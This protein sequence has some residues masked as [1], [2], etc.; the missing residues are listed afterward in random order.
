MSNTVS[1]P[2]RE[3]QPGDW[4]CVWRKATW[5]ARKRK[6]DYN[7]EARFVGPG[8]VL[9]TEP[10]ILP[11]AREAMIW[12]LM[13]TQLWRCSPDQLRP[14]TEAEVSTDLIGR[15]TVL[16]RPVLDQLKVLRRVTDVRRE[17]TFDWDDPDLPETPHAEGAVLPEADMSQSQP[18]GDWE[19]SLE[20]M[21]DEWTR[22]LRA[23]REPGY[24]PTGRERLDPSQ[25]SRMVNRW[26]QLV[27][28]NENRKREGLPP[29]TQ[30][31]SGMPE[32]DEQMKKRVRCLG[33]EHFSLE[34]NDAMIIEEP[35]E[36]IL[37]KIEELEELA[38]KTAELEMLRET[39]REER[40]QEQHL[41]GLLSEACEKR[42]EVC[43]ISFD[44]EDPWMLIQQ[45]FIY[46]KNIMQGPSKE[47]VFNNLTPEHKK[48]F[49]EAMA[50]EIAEVLRSQA[51]R[52]AAEVMTPEELSERIIPMRWVL[53]W[54]FIPGV[55]DKASSRVTS[56]PAA[57]KE[58]GKPNVLAESG[59]Y[60]AKA[61]LVLLGYKHPDLAARDQHTGQRKLA[62]AAPTLTR[63]VRNLRLQASAPDEHEVES[64]DAKSAFLQ[65]AR[66]LEGKPLYTYAVAEVAHALGVKPGTAIQVIGAFYGLTIAPR[67]FWLDADEKLSQR[68]GTVHPCEKCL[69][70]FREEQP[71]YKVVGRIGAHV[72]D[73]LICRHKES[74]RWQKIRKSINEMYLWSPWQKGKFTF[75]GCEMTQLKDHTVTL[76]QTEFSN[77]LRPVEI[78][79]E[80]SRSDGDTLTPSEISQFRGAIMKAAWRAG[81]TGPQ[82]AARVNITASK[83]KAPSVLDLKETNKILKEMKKTANVGLLFPSFNHGKKAEERLTW[84]DMVML[85]FG[86]AAQNNRHDGSS[87]GGCISGF[88]TNKIMDGGEQPMSIIDWRSW[89]LERAAKG[90]NGCEAQALYETED[91]GWKCRIMWTLL[92]TPVLYRGQQEEAAS[93]IESLLIM[94]SRG[95]YDAITLSETAFC[96]MSSA[97]TGTEAMAIQRGTKP[98]TR[99]YATWVPSDLNLADALTK[100][101]PE[102]LKVYQLYLERRVWCVRFQADF[103]SARKAQKLRRRSTT[104][105]R[106]RTC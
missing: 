53:T 60:N 27:S 68:G 65:S 24:E 3:Y 59:Q 23:R 75:A 51:L 41:L 94:D 57:K 106:R 49:E 50:R 42:E 58:K 55:E 105:W 96:G 16:T 9:F 8:R 84:E 97:R 102:A 6:E 30:L 14:A 28:I 5:R 37:H 92:Y 77:A 44:V 101:S 72:D 45:G 71:P 56:K 31:P 69:W 21:S 76:T 79:N 78:A 54:K 15:G 1:R 39:I 100:I 103:V 81:Q 26:Q 64:A 93:R 80:A 38:R 98:H 13:G 82:Y 86:D 29:M 35:Y 52:A 66:K 99:C 90:S 7:P 87:T 85:H 4:V 17:G 20:Q 89:R 74:E 40:R 47:I 36:H 22:R 95:L 25:V 62:T 61:R 91:R 32:D 88:S 43:E 10:A 70:I 104:S 11:D 73:F 63:L 18:A 34:E 83:T 46:T 2:V 48:L 67:M 33:T 12:V 19:K